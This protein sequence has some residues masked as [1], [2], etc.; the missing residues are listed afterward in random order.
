MQVSTQRRPAYLSDKPV[1]IV[2]D[3]ARR[4]YWMLAFF[5]ACAA[6]WAT[7]FGVAKLLMAIV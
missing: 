7:I 4:R 2:L 1:A 5:A 3:D 6:S